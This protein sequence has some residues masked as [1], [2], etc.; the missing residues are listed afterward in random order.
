MSDLIDLRAKIHRLS[1]LVDL[2]IFEL[3]SRVIDVTRAG[4]TVNKNRIS[5][6]NRFGEKASVV[7]YSFS[8][9]SDAGEVTATVNDMSMHE[10]SRCA[11]GLSGVDA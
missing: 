10:V 5:I 9:K 1:A 7:E 6:T 4:Y 8:H 2:G 11:D 3:S